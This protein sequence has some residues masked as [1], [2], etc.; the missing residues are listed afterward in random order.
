[1]T[2]V[3]RAALNAGWT[4]HAMSVTRSWSRPCVAPYQTIASDPATSQAK[5]R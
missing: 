5:H 2:K 3:P 1:M 4:P